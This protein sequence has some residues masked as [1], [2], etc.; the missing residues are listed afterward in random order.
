MAEI[1]ITIDAFKDMP[2]AHRLMRRAK[3]EMQR[4]GTWGN[5]SRPSPHCRTMVL[6]IDD[7]PVSVLCF[8][9]IGISDAKKSKI[10]GIEQL[11]GIILIMGAYT[12]LKWRG[13]G[14]YR[15]LW[16]HLLKTYQDDLEYVVIRSG[17]HKKNTL[18]ITMQHKQGR[19]F[20]EQGETHI[21]SRDWLRPTRAQ[22]LFRKLNWL[23]Y[24]TIGLP[25]V[26]KTAY[27][28]N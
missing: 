4:D 1:T 17:A 8:A 3:R 18:S 21:R 27:S 20:F 19:D 26:E 24:K 9:A 23:R 25:F 28:K 15:I 14:C 16:K 12:A 10:E 7:E 13:K 2:D 22:K 6:K 5:G 11:A